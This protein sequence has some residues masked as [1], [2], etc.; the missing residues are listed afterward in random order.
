LRGASRRSNLVCYDEIAALPSVARNDREAKRSAFAV[1]D[2]HV[3]VLQMLPPQEYFFLIFAAAYEKM[4]PHYIKRSVAVGPTIIRQ[5]GAMKKSI[6]AVLLLSCISFV[7]LSCFAIPAWA[8][9][10]P[11]RPALSS[12]DC[13]KCHA[14]QPAD[15]DANGAKHKSAISCQDCHA[16]HRPSSKNNVPVCS[17][18]H[19]GKVHYEQKVCLSCHTNPHTPLKVT[20]KGPLTDPCLACHTSQIKQLRENKSKH[21]PK[22]CTDCHDVHRKVPQCTQCHKPHSADISA[23]DCRK[24]HKA[25]MPKVVTYAADI[26]SKFCAACHKGP[27]NSL[28]ANKT[29]HSSQTCAT[30]H[31]EKHKML[32]KCQD[33]H[34]AKHPAGIMAKFPVCLACHKSP[35]DLNNWTAEPE[36]KAPA[37]AA[38]K[39]TKKP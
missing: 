26:P 18:C 36:K 6:R 8:A 2:H 16:G 28:A 30:C 20:F 27:F 7:V 3:T 23:A 11:A 4:R 1:V 14:S 5:G 33:C 19:Q 37:P 24:C 9:D 34:G 12:G 32:P 31:Q 39:K 29:K 10:A 15:I 35:H 22:N 17:Q 13:V 38:K 21:S 25:H